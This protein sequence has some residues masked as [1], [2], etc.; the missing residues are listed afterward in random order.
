MTRYQP[1]AIFLLRIATAANFLSAVAGRLGYWDGTPLQ[2]KWQG[3]IAYTGQVNSFAPASIVPFLALSA[4]IIEVIIA[5]LLLI[6]YKTRW[7]ALAG[8]ILTFI[9]FVT[10]SISFGMQTPM[11]YSVLVDCTSALLLAT[12]PAYRWSMDEVLAQKNN[13]YARQ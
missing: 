3:F 6:G 10:M 11:N 2:E 8:S 12:M 7:A 5:L 9:F 4:T 1:Y 13:V